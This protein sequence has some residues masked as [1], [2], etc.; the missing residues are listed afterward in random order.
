MRFATK[1]YFCSNLSTI[2]MRK[3]LLTTLLLSLLLSFSY[4]MAGNTQ[5]AFQQISTQNGLSSS[6]R[7]LV[8]SHEKGYVWIGTRSSDA[9]MATNSGN[10]STIIS[11][12]SLKTKKI[13]FGPLLP[14][15]FSTTIIRKMNSGRH[16]MRI[17]IR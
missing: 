6:V 15:G 1:E 12:T 16:A 11:L 8:V 13:P 10:T 4:K 17:I 7:C 3:T 14:K 5:Y 2:P 9:S